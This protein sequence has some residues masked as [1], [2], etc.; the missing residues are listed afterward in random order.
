MDTLQEYMNEYR[1]QLNKGCIQKAYRGLMDYFGEL[2]SYLKKQHPEFYGSG[3]IYYGYMDMTYFSFFPETLKRRNLK[4]AIVFLHDAFR[5]EVWLSGVNRETQAQYWQ[6]IKEHNWNKYHLASDP[7]SM[8]YIVSQVLV[9]DPDFN[10]LD[11]LSGQIE[12][13]TLEFIGDVERFLSD[14]SA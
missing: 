9:E 11:A 7:R 4:I 10:D 8:D 14:H 5:F 1:E 2:R 13:G 12:R 3:S 6:L